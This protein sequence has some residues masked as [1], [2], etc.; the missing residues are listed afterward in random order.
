MGHSSGYSSMSEPV[1]I[2]VPQAEA[3]CNIPRNMGYK[4]CAEGGAWHPF[5]VSIGK[6]GK[7]IN[8]EKLLAW[9]KQGR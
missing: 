2:T 5:V 9:A 7:R 8:R 6:Q 1:L 4:M 3:M